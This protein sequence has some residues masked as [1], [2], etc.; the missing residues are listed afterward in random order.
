MG[1]AFLSHCGHTCHSRSPLD[2]Q[3]DRLPA[4]RAL[5]PWPWDLAEPARSLTTRRRAGRAL[6]SGPPPPGGAVRGLS[7]QKLGWGGGR[8]P[9]RAW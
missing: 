2:G 5:R 8:L 6:R 1:A 7:P 3:G 9:A 4:S